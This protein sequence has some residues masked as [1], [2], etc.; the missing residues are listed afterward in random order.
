M[1]KNGIET[2]EEG[3]DTDKLEHHA[4]LVRK[5]ETLNLLRRGDGGKLT[6]RGA[7]LQEIEDELGFAINVVSFSHLNHS[8]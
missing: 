2:E 1:I 5:L 6:E 4:K 7:A 3:V 8:H